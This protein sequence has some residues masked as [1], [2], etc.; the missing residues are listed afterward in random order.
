MLVVP[1]VL[2]GGDVVVV[3][4]VGIVGTDLDLAQVFCSFKVK[5]TA[6]LKGAGSILE[7]ASTRIRME[8]T[9]L[10]FAAFWI[11]RFASILSEFLTDSWMVKS[12]LLSSGTFS[13]CIIS[14]S[15]FLL[16]TGLLIRVWF[17]FWIRRSRS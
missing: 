15:L 9:T 6:I 8:S 16:W 13:P 5:K 1:P 7:R 12:T 14:A 2:V 17:Q 3:R 11:A 10:S 4:V